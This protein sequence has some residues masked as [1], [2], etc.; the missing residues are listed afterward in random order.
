MGNY[1]EISDLLFP[2]DIAKLE[3]A[4]EQSWSKDTCYP[5]QQVIWSGENKAL[6]QCA[7]TVLVVYDLY[8]GQ[9][10]YDQD[11]DH[12][13]N[14]LPDDSQHDFSRKQFPD[15]TSFNITVF[16]QKEDILNSP[17]A[18]EANTLER[19]QLLKNKVLHVL[20]LS[21]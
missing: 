6:G 21:I 20:S 19:Y 8:G 4:F 11:N 3:S 18:L 9:I 12:Y 7:V 13:W 1:H 16:K 10:V 14:V 5:P 15:K 17:G 2:K